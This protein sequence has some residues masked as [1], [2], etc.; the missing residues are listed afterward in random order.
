MMNFFR[1]KHSNIFGNQNEDELAPAAPLAFTI[2]LD[3][4]SGEATAP[5]ALR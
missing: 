4:K 5:E 3:S 1:L 2:E